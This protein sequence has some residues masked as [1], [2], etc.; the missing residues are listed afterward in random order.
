MSHKILA[1]GIIL[2]FVCSSVPIVSA[3]D[4]TPP[5]TTHTIDGVMG[6]NNFYISDVVVT[7]NAT[8]DL[9]G[10]N[11]TQYTTW[12]PLYVYSEPLIFAGEGAEIVGY[13]S[14]DN[15]GNVE[16]TKLTPTFAIDKYPPSIRLYGGKRN[17]T[18]PF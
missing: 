4:I 13:R 1:L 6:E 2:L 11:V 7:L 18:I 15:A 3:D 10:V 5:V 14:I 9:S 16:A 8:D 12:G 17:K